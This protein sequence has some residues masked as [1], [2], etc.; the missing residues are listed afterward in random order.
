MLQAALCKESK[1][2]AQDEEKVILHP[3]SC[4]QRMW[5]A[6]Q[7]EQEEEAAFASTSTTLVADAPPH[8]LPASPQTL[9]TD[10]PATR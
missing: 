2:A 10:F 4:V 8:D 5:K 9:T 3:T 1:R 7:D 6:A